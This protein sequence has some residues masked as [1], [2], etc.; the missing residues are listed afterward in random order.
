MNSLINIF[1]DAEK[2]LGKAQAEAAANDEDVYGFRTSVL[3]E[4]GAK[5][6]IQFAQLAASGT[7]TLA[8]FGKAS[9]QLAFEA[10][11]KMIPIFIT[12]I[13]GKELATGIGGSATPAIL[14]AALYGLF[15]AAQSAA[16]LKDGVVS[17]EGDG[18]E[19]SD[20]IPAWL[21][22]GES[23]ITARATKNNVDELKWMNEKLPLRAII[24][25]HAQH[26]Q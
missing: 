4:F 9:V 8:D 15:A 1:I 5:A 2:T 18:T 3:E 26:E 6:A 7:A 11:Q 16:G 24:S 21:S 20:S 19:T 14:T 10:L 23:V 13:A 17:L 25:S 12:N 22:K